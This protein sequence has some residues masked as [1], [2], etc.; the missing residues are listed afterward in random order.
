MA[1]YPFLSDEWFAEARRIVDEQVPEI[2][3]GPDVSMNVLVTASPFGND[4][5][6]HLATIDGTGDLGTGHLTN[7]DLTLTT[8]YETAREILVTGDPQSA[9]QAFMEGKVKIQGD[10]TK[11]MAAQSA[12]TGPGAPELARALLTITEL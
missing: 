4:R 12:G 9:L 7:P 8:D 11:L 3:T 1:K 5:R 6:L 10:L 2:S